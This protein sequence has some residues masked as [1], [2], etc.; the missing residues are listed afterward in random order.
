LR[1]RIDGLIPITSRRL[2]TPDTYVRWRTLEPSPTAGVHPGVGDSVALPP[3]NAAVAMAQ[4]QSSPDV[5]KTILQPPCPQRRADVA[6][7]IVGG[8]SPPRPAC[9]R[10][11]GL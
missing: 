9:L 8:R 5:P 10:V 4:S 6:C 11:Q 2:S 7:S 3:A 1:G